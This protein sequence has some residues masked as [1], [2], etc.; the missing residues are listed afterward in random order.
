M[1]KIPSLPSDVMKLIFSSA[2]IQLKEVASLS[3]EWNQMVQKT[4]STLFESYEKNPSLKI[5]AEHAKQKFKTNDSGQTQN[6][7]RVKLVF[8][9]VMNTAKQLGYQEELSNSENLSTTHL[10]AVADWIKQEEAN[11][12]LKCANKI[13]EQIPSMEKFLEKIQNLS[14]TEKTKE[15]QEWMEKNSEALKNIESISFVNSNLTALPSEITYLQNLEELKLDNNKL[16]TIPGG[17]IGSLSK[18]KILDLAH[19]GLKALP[20]EIASLPLQWLAISDNPMLFPE[21][22]KPLLLKNT[23]IKYFADENDIEIVSPT[24]M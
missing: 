6:M 17:I 9:E 14:P 16:S 10:Q 2:E 4:L 13:A 5:Y 3:K 24:D 11:N 23:I 7:Q 1:E 19:N 18:L 22:L 8:Q 20:D 15:I 12:L 21:N